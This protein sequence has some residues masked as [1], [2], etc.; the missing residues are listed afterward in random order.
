M[1]DP[2]SGLS[3]WPLS[4]PSF[5]L[6][7]PVPE[8]SLRSVGAQRQPALVPLRN[9]LSCGKGNLLMDVALFMGRSFRVGWGPSW[10]LAHCGEPLGGNA[11]A[12]L[13]PQPD[14]QVEFG[15]LPKSKPIS[16][17][18]FRVH[19]ERVVAVEQQDSDKALALLQHPLQIELEHSKVSME[20]ECPF[21]QPNGGVEALHQYADWITGV[22]QVPGAVDGV[23]QHWNL[24]WTLCAALWGRLAVE[25]DPESEV[26]PAVGYT[27]QLE[28]RRSFSAW[29]AHSSAPRV[30]EEV[31]R[32][33]SA[34]HCSHVDAIFSY[35]TA[36]RIGEACKLAH[37]S[38]DHR[39]AL[40]LSQAGGSQNS[41]ELL[42]LQLLDWSRL[43]TDSFVQEDRLR[44]FALLAGKPVWQ[45]SDGC[46]NVCSELDWQ[47]CLAVHLWYLLPPTASVADALSKYQAA[48]EGTS[49]G[50]KY[51]CAPLPPYVHPLER[52]EMEET[53]EE[54]RPLYDVCFHLLKLYSDRH[55][56][57]QQLL[58][59]STVT[60]LRLDFRLSWHLWNVLQALNYT[61]LSPQH[62]GL[63]HTS[64][65][66]QLESAG[67]WDM[68][69]FVLLHIPDSMHREQAVRA[70]LDL[71]C[72]LVETEESV[73]RELFLTEKLLVPVRWIHEAKAT[74]ARREGDRHREALHLYKAGHWSQCHRLVIQHLAAD[75]IINENHDYLLEFLEGLSSPERSVQ[76]QDWEAAG[77]VFLDYIRVIQSLRD[78]QQLESP[79]YELERLHLEVTSLCSRIELI[80][81]FT[82]KDR[83]AQSEMAKRV[84][85]ILRAVLGLQ[86][87]TDASSAAPAHIP[88]RYLAPLISR[89]PM[90]EDYALEELRSITQSYLRELVGQ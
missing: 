25:L 69:V 51:A 71:H 20:E 61:H 24:V 12:L 49:E 75:C 64:Y 74:R 90:P 18:T 57:L 67:L 86:Q 7:P 83:L 19:L 48:F 60:S 59:P 36:H 66:A 5:G 47:R 35:L 9:S 77:R 30:E 63:L 11:G 43:Q 4:R 42:S 33:S 70:M 87:G 54:Q 3:P 40:L 15:F 65:A 45:G 32:F 62:Q 38:G 29:L 14:L 21:I 76:I 68:A 10:T 79:G 27:N 56:S 16:E 82:A 34:Q 6:P 84:A 53:A 2:S 88:L 28:R 72:P 23:V 37:K 78:I 13:D 41:R 44:I 50:R 31:Q 81:C 85:N 39:L 8:V 80:P 89:L 46:V 1:A 55:Y 17:S 73:A 58:D 26:E 22:T 52:V